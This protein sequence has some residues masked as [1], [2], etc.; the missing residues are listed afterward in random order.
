MGQM[1]DVYKGWI[2][3]YPFVSIEDPFDQ[4]DWDAYK[5]C[6][7]KIGKDQ[8]IVGDDLLVTNPKRIAKALEVGA[9]NALLLKVNQIGSI[10]ESIEAATMAQKAG[11]GVMV[12]HRSGETEDCFI[13]DLVVGLRTGQIKTG[14]PCRSERL[15]KYNQLLRIEEELGSQASYAGRKFRK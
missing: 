10:S 12:S 1:I 2:E 5:S 6:M 9:C 4:D 15:A 3:K 13:A 14:A 11:W 7:E 8:Q